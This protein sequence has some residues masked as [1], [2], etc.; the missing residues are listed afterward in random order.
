MLFI[1]PKKGANNVPNE[2]EYY[3]ENYVDCNNQRFVGYG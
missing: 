3:Y 1:L 2:V